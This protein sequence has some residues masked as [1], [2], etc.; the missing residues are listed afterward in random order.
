MNSQTKLFQ[1][2]SFNFQLN[3][4][5][6]IGVLILAFSTSFLIRTQSSQFGFELNE[7]D[8]FFNF[9]ATEYIIENG[10][11]EYLQWNDDKSWYPHGRDVSAT[12][13]VMLHVTAAITYQIFGGNSSLYDFTILF[14]A[15]IGSLTVI[16]IFLLVRLF[17]GTSAGL[18]AS[19]L[20]AISLPIVMRGS[21]GW[22]KSEPLGIFYGLLGVYLFLS[23][24]NSSNKKIIFSKMIF[25]GV[26]LSFAMAS[27]GGNQFFIIPLGLFILVLPFF[28]KDHK[29]LLWSVPL[30]VTIFLLISSSFE[31]PGP[32]FVYGLAGLSLIIPTMFLMSS[33]FIQ[34][35]SK[36]EQKLRN[37]LILLICII[38]IGSFLLILNN[39][40]NTLPLPSFRYLNA[41]NPFLITT[42]PLTDS[43]AEHA[44]TSLKQSFFFHSILMIFSGLGVW[45]ILSKK[46]FGTIIKNEFKAFIIIIG[47]TGVYVSSAFIRLEVFASISLIIFTSVGLSILSREIFKIN[48]SGKRSYFIKTCFVVIILSLFIIPLCFPAGNW[49]TSANFPATILNGGTFNPSSN[50]WLETLEWIKMN[51][52]ENSVVAAWWD[53]GYW[54][55][56]L[57]ERSTLSDN[58]TLIDHVI[59][60]TAKMFLSSPDDS[61]NMLKEMKADYVVVFVAANRVGDTA[62]GQPVYV[63]NGGGDES[64]IQWFVKISELPFNNYIESDGVTPTDYFLN[65]TMLG[66]MIPYTPL[67]YY[68]YDYTKQAES[69]IPGFI[70]ISIKDIKYADDTDP[71]KLVYSSSS[72]NDDSTSLTSVLVYQVNKNYSPEIQ[73]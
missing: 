7:F 53:Y 61:W 60:S 28:K 71:V 25:G 5:V 65:E 64:K 12:S 41:I 10:F 59:Q 47:I 17:A 57:G 39:E 16:V 1:A 73:K 30:F 56:T 36:N 32:S 45:L 6:I 33:I 54:I 21:L 42:D 22:F 58:S 49:I 62:D 51:T 34:K 63:L 24:I 8:P 14:P 37:T 52:P 15:V 67:A 19:I 40:S 43:V 11:S 31:R 50:D 18:F 26:I 46:S 70:P 29:I 23:A 20:F 55:Q 66:N 38:I 3:H 13:Q 35:I 68:N 44:T 72:F 48:L 69:Y 9:R 2:G 4:L 27:W